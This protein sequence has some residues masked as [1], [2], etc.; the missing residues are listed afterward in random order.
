MPGVD[1]VKRLLTLLQAFLDEGKEDPVLLL[2]AV[3][4][5]T[6]VPMAIEDRTTETDLLFTH[7][8][9]LSAAIALLSR[10]ALPGV[11]GAG[12]RSRRAIVSDRGNAPSQRRARVSVASVVRQYRPKLT[13][14]V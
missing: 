4:E 5:G 2:P 6:D 3:E 1:D 11:C 10:I 9:F 13:T 12:P 8:R 7:G 14:V